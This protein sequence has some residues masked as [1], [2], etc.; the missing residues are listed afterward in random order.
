[1]KTLMLG[2]EALARGAY[3]AG[4]A[5]VSSYP[6]TPSTEIT[7]YAS[8]YPEIY[9][10]WAP[11]EKVA[12]E[13]ACGASLGGVRALSCMKHVGLNVAADPLY[14]ASYTG[15]NGGLVVVV[16]DDPGMHSSQNEQDSR[17][18]ARGAQL[19][20]LEPADSQEAVDFMKAAYEISEKYDTPVLIRTTTRMAHARSLVS[21]SPRAD[22]ERKPYTKDPMK[23]VM[24]PGMAKLRHVVVEKRMND[25]QKDAC[26]MLL[27]RIERGDDSI[28]V[29]CSG[30]AYQYVKEAAPDVSV[31]KLGV[32]N[33]LPRALIEEFARSVDR[34]YVIEELEPVFEEQIKSW[35]I[36]CVGKELTGRQGELSARRVMEILGRATPEFQ[37]PGQLPGRPPVM[38][39]G[40][41]HR[42]TYYVLSKL[43]LRATGDIGCYTLGALKPNEAID[44]CLCMGASIGMSHGLEKATGG[45]SSRDTVAVIGDSTFVHSGITG[46]INAVYNHGRSTV[47]ILDNSTTAMTGHQPNPTVGYDIRRQETYRLDLETVCR[48]VGVNDVKTVDPYDLDELEAALKDSLSRDE[49]SV[50]IARR[51]CALLS[52]ERKPVYA[53]DPDKCRKCGMCLKLGCPAIERADGKARINPALCVGCDLCARLCKFSAI[54]GP[55]CK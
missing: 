16:A 39:P 8:D 25:L 47:L 51:P 55:S 22:I 2:N 30:A 54:G 29:I 13:T 45:E 50:I 21:E 26:A 12:V 3:E 36:E 24:M 53:V 44:S 38:C 15:V 5:V 28:G 23:Y 11:N 32:V 31:L 7:E 20:M 52:K 18:H 6:G 48:A 1:M 9:V 4:V 35:G 17:N 40:C 34:L 19:P 42:G 27:N 37:T 14:T 41:P 43:H 10:E 49:V 46:L 33:P